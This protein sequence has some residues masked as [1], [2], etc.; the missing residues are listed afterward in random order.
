MD[1]TELKDFLTDLKSTAEI[2]ILNK[3]FAKKDEY[4]SLNEPPIE[5]MKIHGKR[6]WMQPINGKNKGEI[7]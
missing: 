5:W 7:V 2:W 4:Y 6:F 1:R 3:L